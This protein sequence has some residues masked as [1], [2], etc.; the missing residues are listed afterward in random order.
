MVTERFC[1]ELVGEMENFGR[2]S[3]G[4][5]SVSYNNPLEAKKEKKKTTQREN[6]PFFLNLIR[7]L[8]SGL[9]FRSSLNR[10]IWL[11]SGL[12]MGFVMGLVYCSIFC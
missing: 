9:D 1:D 12:P 11:E 10:E 7:Y 5:N 2:W 4:S 8:R 6:E 3:D